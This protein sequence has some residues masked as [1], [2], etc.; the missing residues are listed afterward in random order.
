MLNNKTITKKFKKGKKIEE[1][2]RRKQNKEE[3]R[4]GK[5]KRKKHNKKKKNNKRKSP[6]VRL[7]SQSVHCAVAQT[8]ELT[9]CTRQ[10]GS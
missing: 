8:A 6:S 5:K 3:S 10:L 1:E 7:V 2:S 9:H 4:R